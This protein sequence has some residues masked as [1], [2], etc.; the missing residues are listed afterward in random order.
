MFH[1]FFFSVLSDL[2]GFNLVFKISLWWNKTSCPWFGF[3][4]VADDVVVIV[5]L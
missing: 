2:I 4:F 3:F 1:D 5:A